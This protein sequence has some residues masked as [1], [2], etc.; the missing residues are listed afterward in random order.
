MSLTTMTMNEED[1]AKPKRALQ[2]S[3]LYMQK[4]SLSLKEATSR[5]NELLKFVPFRIFL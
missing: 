4:N 5:W 3:L 2:A 1:K